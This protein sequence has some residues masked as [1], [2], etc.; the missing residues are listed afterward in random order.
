MASRFR[1][2]EDIAR[3]LADWFRREG[4]R[5]AAIARRLKIGQPSISRVL[6]GRFDPER[7]DI[8][9]Q[10]CDHAKVALLET[11]QTRS[12]AAMLKR[13]LNE[14]WDG[15]VEDAERVAGLLRAIA[16]LRERQ[17]HQGKRRRTKR[18]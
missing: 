5:Q 17:G 14:T 7:S 8:A 18:N 10:L 12:P 6:A 15:T 4:V 2:P 1:R 16:S 9:K 11:E 3:D 13:L